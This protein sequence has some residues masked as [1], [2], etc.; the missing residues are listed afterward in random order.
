MA[1]GTKITF[2]EAELEAILHPDFFYTKYAAM[3]KVMEL[4]SETERI[5]R[6][7]IVQHPFLADHTNVVSPK[8][9]RGEN[10]RKLPYMVLDY[11][12]R[13]STETIFAF[14]TMFWWGK[15]FSFTLHLQH[16]ALEH[17]RNA[18]I[19]NISELSGKQFYY[20]VYK[21]PWE[22]HFDPDNYRPLDEILNEPGFIDSLRSTPFIKLSRKIPI[23][24]FE[25]VAA[26]AG[27]TLIVL[28]KLLQDSEPSPL[29]REE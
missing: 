14:R 27:E 12:R 13:F 21:T 1:Q 25:H 8:I 4:L 2:S 29:E 28:L 26:Y 15:E 5:L 7:I 17:F 22:Y 19:K 23:K 11:P 16:A 20:S 18:I 10:Y 24:D 9:F 6:E 3:Q